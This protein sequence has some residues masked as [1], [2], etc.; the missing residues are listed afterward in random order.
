MTKGN[1]DHLFIPIA[2][3]FLASETYVDVDDYS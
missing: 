3:K 2:A 1:G